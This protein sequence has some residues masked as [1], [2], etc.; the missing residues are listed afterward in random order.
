MVLD[1]IPLGR[2][3]TI[4]EVASAV[5]VLASPAAALVTGSSLLVERG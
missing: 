1:R 5:V 4:E 3:G 2:V